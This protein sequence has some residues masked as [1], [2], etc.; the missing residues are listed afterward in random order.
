MMTVKLSGEGID[1]TGMRKD[2]CER[3]SAAHGGR[4]E[5]ECGREARSGEISKM[6]LFDTVDYYVY[7]EKMGTQKKCVIAMQA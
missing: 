4:R 5:W 6:Y 7:I 1:K 3:E 2:T